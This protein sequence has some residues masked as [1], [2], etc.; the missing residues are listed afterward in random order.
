MQGEVD[1][2]LLWSRLLAEA[3]LLACPAGEVSEA[4]KIAAVGWIQLAGTALGVRPDGEL[5]H[6]ATAF[7]DRVLAR[8]NDPASASRRADLL[9]ALGCLHSDPVSASTG[10][11]AGKDA[12][13]MWERTAKAQKGLLAQH[14]QAQHPLPDIK[15]MLARALDFFE[16]ALPDRQGEG[17]GITLKA[18]ANTLLFSAMANDAVPDA[19][20]VK[21]LCNE[22]LTLL[23]PGSYQH[24]AVLGILRSLG[25]PATRPQTAATV[26]SAAADTPDGVL[27]R[28]RRMAEDEPAGAL[29][30]LEDAEALFEAHGT[31]AQRRSRLVTM[32]QLIPRAHGGAGLDQFPGPPDEAVKA[33]S[34]AAQAEHWSADRLAATCIALALQSARSD[35]EETGLRLVQVSNELSPAIASHQAAIGFLLGELS[36]G[37]AVNLVNADR[38][39]DAVGMYATAL[40]PFVRLRLPA[41]ALELTA[42]IADL[43]GRPIEGMGEKVLLGLAPVAF[44]VERHLGE[45]GV[46]ALRGIYEVAIGAMGE[47]ETANSSTIGM[48]V[49]LAKGARFDAMLRAG[50]EFDWRRDEKSLAVQG[51]IEALEKQA[52]GEA[53]FTPLDDLLLVTAVSE[54]RTTGGETAAQRL[55]NLQQ[56]F[57]RHVNDHLAATMR[58]PA[59]VNPEVIQHVLGAR[60]VLLDYYFARRSETLRDMFV[61]VYTRE[62]ITA[63]RNPVETVDLVF[64]S[65]SAAGLVDSVALR[66]YLARTSVLKDPGNDTL[67]PDARVRLAEDFELLLG[68]STWQHLES[69][70]KAGKDHLCIRPHGALRYYPLQLLGPAGHDLAQHW[71]V[72]ILPSLEC[73]LRPAA[74]QRTEP[75][76]ALG[77]SYRGSTFELTS[78]ADEVETVA[79][80]FDTP[81]LLDESVTEASL[82]TA[83]RTARRVHLC[84]HGANTP[85]SPLFHHLL[86]TPG[87]EGGGRIC[88]YELLGQDL[89][90]LDVLSLGSCDSALGRFD[91][92][93]NLSGLPAAFLAAGA[94]TLVA[95]LWEL[96]D[97]AATR[98]FVGFHRALK[99]GTPRLD[100]FRTAQLDVRAAFPQARDWA[101][102]CYLGDW[103]REV[104]PLPADIPVRF[105][106]GSR[107]VRP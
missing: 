83:L 91:A 40:V 14:H 39:V 60:T 28:A 105:E 43:A 89:R 13:R 49:Q 85:G 11:G 21:A 74:P 50:A 53:G 72:T 46:Q 51:Q 44:E 62:A 17:R 48:L 90:G 12:Q 70:R 102:F 61:I 69:L 56:A 106:L 93:D 96:L 68:T 64:A 84:A 27:S 104:Q 5:L 65:D 75:G 103:D 94:S 1:I 54:Q 100:A 33:I 15:T 97:E 10:M 77:L 79:G 2:A 47:L 59:I 31:E 86:V 23:E 4:L 24:Q 35:A 34:Q 16:R 78:A 66:T 58:R 92:G 9:Q 52:G 80:I 18:I 41:M 81:P 57:D 3:C 99:A 26:S 7:A 38:P 101:A 8:L 30:T 71:I 88:A 36:M 6:D 98:F 32:T 82:L 107:A 95:A 19:E 29:A 73:L 22:A 20:R 76:R 87:T 37:A 25:A 55:Q 67:H 42:R 63:F 45:P